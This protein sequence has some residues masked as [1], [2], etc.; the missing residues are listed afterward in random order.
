MLMCRFDRTAW[1]SLEPQVQLVAQT[2]EEVVALG[3]KH[4]HSFGDL[5][6]GD[7][8]AGCPVSPGV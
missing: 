6:G 4:F 2:C 8:V 3:A 7:I 1:L 5:V